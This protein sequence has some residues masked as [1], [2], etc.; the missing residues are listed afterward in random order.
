METADAPL[1]AFDDVQS[2]QAELTAKARAYAKRLGVK[3]DF[4]AATVLP[5][6]FFLNGAHYALDEVSR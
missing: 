1:A 2:G 5:G 6:S 3:V 4:E